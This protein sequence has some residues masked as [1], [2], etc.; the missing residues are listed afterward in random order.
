MIQI[1]KN[2]VL[3]IFLSLVHPIDLILHILIEIN[4]PY[5]LD[6]VYVLQDRSKI[7]KDAILNDPNSQK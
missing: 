6:I 1:A 5:D 3:A 7:I 4:S 2:E